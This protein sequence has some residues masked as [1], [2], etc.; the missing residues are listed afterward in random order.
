MYLYAGGRFDEARAELAKAHDLAGDSDTATV[1][2]EILLL[3]GEH[4]AALRQF[5]SVPDDAARAYGL[6]LV[7]HA[8]G[9]RREADAAL[10]RLQALAADTDPFLLAEVHAQRGEVQQALASLERAR[11]SE[12]PRRRAQA[13][14]PPWLMAA[15][16]LLA[17]LR[18]DPRWPDWL[19][20]RE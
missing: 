4:D 13:G 15:S 17:P 19:T 11:P 14:Y 5:E 6:A 1:L 16:P 18:G 3:R 2:G 20:R 12:D 9:R 8:Q 7:H 10:A